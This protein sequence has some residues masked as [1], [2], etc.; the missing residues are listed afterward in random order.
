[1]KHYSPSQ[2]NMYLRCSMQWAYRYIHV[3]KIPPSSSQ[4]QGSSYHK[5]MEFNLS[6]K[7]E[8]KKDLPLEEVKASYSDEFDNKIKEVDWN[9]KEKS[10]GIDKVKGSLKDEGIKITELAHTVF[11]PQIHPK[12][13]ESPFKISFDN[14]DYTLDGVIDVV[15]INNIVIDHKTTGKTPSTISQQEIIQGAIY[16]I[17]KNTNQ[18][19]FN[20]VIKQKTP[21]TITLEK[22]MDDSDKEYVLKVVS[23]IDSAVNK[24]LFYPNRASMMCSKKNC[25]YWAQCEK[26]WGGK[27]K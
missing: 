11:N 4:I 10:Q 15:D 20:Y 8:S 26:D 23:A 21:K 22:Q 14:T 16:S 18:V 2:I 19:M 24:E 5:A 25:G 12:E 6:Q 9:D 1:M 13:V 17:A 3:L 27:V 7:I